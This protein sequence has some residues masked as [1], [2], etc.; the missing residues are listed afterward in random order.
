MSSEEAKVTVMQQS[1]NDSSAKGLARSSF[2]FQLTD[3]RLFHVSTERHTL[4]QESE[5]PPSLSIVLIKG[6]EPPTASEFA[7]LLQLEA[8]LPHSDAPEC[9]ISLSVEGYFE[10]I[11]DPTTLKPEVI[12]RFKAADAILLLWPY[13]RET[14]HNLTDRMRLGVPPLP[15]IDA[16]AL[17]TRP[18]DE[19]AV[20]EGLFEGETE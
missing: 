19:S 3:I 5:E 10:A 2:P 18:V 14:L 15:V 13:L 4:E 8:D 20:E 11:I 7:L 6:D 1:N 12:E 17:L 16:R 9:S